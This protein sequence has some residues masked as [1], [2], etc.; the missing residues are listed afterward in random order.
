M[1]QS[2][3]LSEKTLCVH[4]C[5]L[6]IYLQTVYQDV[7]EKEILQILEFQFAEHRF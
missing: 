1:I 4:Y 2:I 6:L 3:S 5:I 7:F